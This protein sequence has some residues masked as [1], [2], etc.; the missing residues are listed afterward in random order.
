MFYN[1]KEIY[2]VKNLNK[3]DFIIYL[4]FLIINKYKN[5]LYFEFIIR[6]ISS[7]R[8]ENETETF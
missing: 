8:L 1:N 4:S 6:N 7:I 3:K 5:N 2:F